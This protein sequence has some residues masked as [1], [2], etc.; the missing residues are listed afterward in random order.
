MILA[1][2]LII[3]ALLLL[4]ISIS[5]IIAGGVG[6]IIVF[7]DVIVC[8]FIIAWIVKKLIKRRRR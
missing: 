2:I 1:M 3:I 7:G 6:F 4:V 5:A 8:V